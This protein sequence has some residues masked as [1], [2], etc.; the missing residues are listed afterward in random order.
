[1]GLFDV[2]EDKL[3]MAE[4]SEEDSKAIIYSFHLTEKDAR[5]VESTLSDFVNDI[6][7]NIYDI[8]KG[9]CYAKLCENKYQKIICF[10]IESGETKT[11]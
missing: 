7:L 11:I 1:M 8:Y 6:D 3:Y 4:I 9:K 10:D 5:K 2:D